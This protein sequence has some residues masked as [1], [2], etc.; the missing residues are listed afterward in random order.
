M[1][2]PRNLIGG[3]LT[4]LIGAAYLAM[5]LN[6]RASALDDAVGPAGFPKALGYAVIGLG[7]ILCIQSVAAMAMR[8]PAPRVAEDG[9]EA[10]GGEGLHG[11]LRAA[12]MLALGIAYLL[13]VRWLG[14][15]PS[16]ALL[17]IAAAVY[18]G[19]PFSLRVVAI[20]IAGAIVYWLVFVLVLGIPLPAGVLGRL[21]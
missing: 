16:V 13:I 9:A 10:E 17:M 6:I 20:G 4:V 14:Y 1:T 11:M 21:F 8:R 18:L 19:T 3:I 15:L 7:L 5:T 12:G 2:M